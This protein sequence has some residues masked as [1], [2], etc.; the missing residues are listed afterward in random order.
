MIE[1]AT[2]EGRQ[3]S[4]DKGG[5]ELG[6]KAVSCQTAP[7]NRRDGSF[8]EKR[9]SSRRAAL[10]GLGGRPR[11]PRGPG[12]FQGQ[13]AASPGWS[14][15]TVDT[16]RQIPGKPIGG[17]NGVIQGLISSE[18]HRDIIPE[19]EL[20]STVPQD[21][22]DSSSASWSHLPQPRKSRLGR[23]PACHNRLDAPREK[24]TLRIRSDLIAEYRDWSWEARCQ[25]SELVER[26]LL[27]YRRLRS[28]RQ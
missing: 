1:S 4:Q 25:L 19:N 10:D 18:E 3:P 23:P 5:G 21:A 24:V 11:L 20:P 12:A 17:I 8:S 16:R 22:P 28:Q 14:G 27:C 6:R 9:V 13:P 2:A 7:M 15:K 26:S